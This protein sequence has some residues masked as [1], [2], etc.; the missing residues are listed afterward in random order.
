VEK[1]TKLTERDLDVL[2]ILWR[3]GSGTVAE[4]RSELPSPVGYTGVLKLLQ[5]LE[6]KG[7]V[8]HEQEGRAHRYFATVGPEE[9]GAPALRKLV[10]RVF[11]G[12]V[13]LALARLISGRKLDPAEVERMKQLLDEAQKDPQRRRKS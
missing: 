8:R 12:S 6:A 5:L 2:N 3:R 11:Q 1:R 13:E 4:V 10:D 7:M 9:A